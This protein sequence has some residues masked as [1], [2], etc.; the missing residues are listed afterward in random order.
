MSPTILPLATSSLGSGLQ[1]QNVPWPLLCAGVL[2]AATG[3]AV[4]MRRPWIG[5][6]LLVVLLPF[7]G[8]LTQLLGE[9]TVATVM[10]SAKDVILFLILLSGLL[11]GRLTSLSPHIVIP[12]FLIVTLAA[13]AGMQSETTVQGLY[14]WR[15]NYEPLLLLAAVPTA[16]DSHS[17]AKVRG[18]IVITAQ[19]AAAISIATW[20]RGIVWLYDLRILPITDGGNFPS[21]YFS[22]GS[23]APRAFSPYT[24]PNEMA[25]ATG[26]V[27]ALIWCSKRW[28][29]RS[30]IAASA[31]PTLA[32]FLSDSRSGLIGLLL[33][34]VVMC[35]RR[36]YARFP[37]LSFT[38][39]F[40]G[41]TGAAGF[42]GVFLASQMGSS[43][44]PSVAG[45]A[46]SLQEALPSVF[47]HPLGLGL[48]GVGPRAYRYTTTP[49]LVES[50]WL[51]IALETGFIVLALFLYLLLVL[52]RIGIK[53]KTLAGFLPVAAISVSLVSQVVLPTLQEGAVSY[54]L[55]I[56][57]SIGLVAANLSKNTDDEIEGASSSVGEPRLKGTR[58][59]L[60]RSVSRFHYRE[61]DDDA[62][63][64][65]IKKCSPPPPSFV[66]ISDNKDY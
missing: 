60:G 14:G 26:C 54:T 48:G 15:N 30:K 5:V 31:L 12:V 17:A 28:G 23:L 4:I 46:A 55:W 45:H 2:I 18:A 11:R 53:A 63:G 6:L 40:T 32:I 47:T 16:L 19:L 41:A 36:L 20:S 61:N 62:I 35:S 38:F 22:S 65:E 49:I 56:V 33:L 3:S 52:T 29:L 34:V 58:M 66:K 8:I 51:L 13:L 57:V 39:L 64:M 10:G 37:S 1:L 44:D 50:F 59:D 43:G 24:A 25:V 21:S 9:G 42:V 27:I 7:N